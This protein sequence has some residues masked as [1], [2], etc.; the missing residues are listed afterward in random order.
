MSE[1][2]KVD[3]LVRFVCAF[4]NKSTDDDPRYAQLNV[5]WAFSEATQG[6][7]AHVACLRAAVHDSIPLAIE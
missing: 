4:C 7:G 3:G 5:A 6:L 1:V 2:P